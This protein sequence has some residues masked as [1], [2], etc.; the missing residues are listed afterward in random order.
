MGRYA[1]WDSAEI[2]RGQATIGFDAWS[3][4]GGTCVFVCLISGLLLAVNECMCVL[5]GLRVCIYVFMYACMYVCFDVK[6]IISVCLF[7]GVWVHACMI[8]IHKC[9]DRLDHYLQMYIH[10]YICGHI[11]THIRMCII[12]RAQNT[13]IRTYTHTN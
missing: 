12:Q 8:C 11:H 10:V 6:L 7:F 1:F 13:D 5:A 3:A 2:G 4:T 9:V